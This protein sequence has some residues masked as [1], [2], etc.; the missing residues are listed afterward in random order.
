MRKA[1]E[2]APRNGLFVILEDT[3]HGTFAVARWSVETA[4]WLDEDE[5]PIQLNAT[6]WHLPQTLDEQVTPRRPQASDWHSPTAAKGLT[7][8]A[9]K[10]GPLTGPSNPSV[11]RTHRETSSTGSGGVTAQPQPVAAPGR[12]VNGR[13]GFVGLV[14]SA[15]GK[16]LSP[17]VFVGNWVIPRQRS[18]V[19]MAACVLVG[20]AFAPLLYR[21]DAGVRL[22]NLTASD[23]D[24]GLKQA[25]EREQEHT[26]K[27]ASDMTAARR[28]AE[29]Q[30][31]L[32]RQAS[33]A[34]VR[35]REASDRALAGMRQALQLELSK[36]EK[37]TGQLT[38]AQRDNAAQTALTRKTIDDSPAERERVIGELR[39][40]LKQQEEETTRAR[41]KI[42]DETVQAKQTGIRVAEALQ[43]ERDK[44]EDLRVELATVRREAEAQVA[45]WRSA[46]GE[47]TRLEAANA[48]AT[49]VLREALRQAQDKAEKFAGELAATRREVEAQTMAARAASNEARRIADTSKQ[50]AEEQSQTLREAQ[51]KAEKLATDLAAARREIQTQVSAAK[52]QAAAIKET[53]ERSADEQRRALQQERDRAEKL[54]VELAETRSS[55]Q[56]QTKAKAADDIARDNDLAA[57]RRELEKARADVTVARESLEAERTRTEQI[58]QRLTTIQVAT[59]DHGSRSLAPAAPAVGQPSTA[60]SSVPDAQTTTPTE[61]AVQSPISTGRSE[62]SVERAGPHAVRLIARANILLDQGNIGAAR[63]MLDRAAEMGSAEAL[64]WLAETYDPLLLSERKTFGTR[65]DIAK[66]RELYGKALA[67][68]V[69]EAKLRLDALQQ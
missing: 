33:E 3:A 11:E 28:E 1:I 61:D 62:A 35:Q 57:A 18:I 43:Q 13:T 19:T 42:E 29:S 12:S 47:T 69:S 48:R 7:A 27:L 14:G 15:C 51:G 41:R 16:V 52:A 56:T 40:A 26:N 49:D 38:E 60:A 8:T 17:F 22:L 37:L 53:V 66:A 20:A 31:A 21:S 58:E 2:T 67:G 4:R 39:Q 25:L 36:T 9:D 30:A 23:H 10:P 59:R 64:F 63:N 5:T 24:T 55:L 45:T 54:T 34:A 68:G 65:S 32:I 46:S 6:H 50:N 44:V